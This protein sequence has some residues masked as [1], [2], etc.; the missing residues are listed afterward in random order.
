MDG[1]RRID[2]ES[3]SVE[4]HA[5]L[6]GLSFTLSATSVQED[7]VREAEALLA[8][9]QLRRENEIPNVS[10]LCV[11]RAIFAD[12]LPKHK[13]EGITLH[14][15]L[16][17]HP[18][19]GLAFD[20]L[21]GASTDSTLLERIA[22]T[23]SEAGLLELL[24]VAKLR[25]GKRNING[26][27]GEEEIERVRELNFTT[28]Y[29]FMW[30]SQGSADDLSQP[31]LTINMETGTNP[32]PGGRPVESSFHEDAALALWD[33]ITSSIRRPKMKVIPNVRGSKPVAFSSWHCLQLDNTLCMSDEVMSDTRRFDEGTAFNQQSTWTSG[34]NSIAKLVSTLP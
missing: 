25:S 32:R 28:G 10:G 21:A 29:S 18:D 6:K 27:D 20:S 19:M 12:P 33:G 34:S 26:I 17:G 22:H 1:D 9:L 5:H 4:A 31:Y 16:P 30:E 15:G 7:S 2:M 23:D 24:S 11:W 8:R 14:V 3:V 13:S